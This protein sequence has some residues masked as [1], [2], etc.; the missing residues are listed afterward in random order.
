VADE[1][2]TSRLLVCAVGAD[3]Y[4]GL[5]LDAARQAV[6]IPG[7]GL[8]REPD[9]DDHPDRLLTDQRHLYAVHNKRGR[10]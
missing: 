9:S 2:P 7:V 3:R 6:A 8:V 1:A 4:A 10:L 5:S